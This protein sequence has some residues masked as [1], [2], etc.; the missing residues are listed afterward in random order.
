L[1]K[2]VNYKADKHWSTAVKLRDN[3]TCQVCGSLNGPYHAHHIV[4]HSVSQE[5]RRQIS[6]GT[7][8]CTSCHLSYHVQFGIGSEETFYK[9]KKQYT[10]VELSV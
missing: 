1:S 10:P 4:P 3:N 7:T 8:L 6:N 2:R 9:F 5:L